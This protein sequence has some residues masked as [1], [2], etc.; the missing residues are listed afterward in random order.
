MKILVERNPPPA[1]LSRLGVSAW[2]IWEK[3]ESTFPWQY[4]EQETCFILAGA[5]TV[6]PD[7]G[8]PVS[9]EAGDMVTFPEGLK[10]VW[11]ITKAVRKHY[12]FG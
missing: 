7:G 5:A 11:T 3:E 9:F 1:K 4:D 2:P 8:E 6:T 12:R 10:C